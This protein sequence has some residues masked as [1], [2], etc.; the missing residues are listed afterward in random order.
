MI[1]AVMY[2]GTTTPTH[3]R[4]YQPSKGR[5]T[6]F[7]PANTTNIELHNAA[8]DDYTSQFL[9]YHKIQ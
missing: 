1:T 5:E 6:T 3:A 7:K 8:V 2:N 9:E 4:W